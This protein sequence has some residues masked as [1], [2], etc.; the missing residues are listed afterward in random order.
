MSTLLSSTFKKKEMQA[1]TFLVSLVICGLA[2]SIITAPKIIELGIPFPF[3][4]IV[5]SILTYPIVDC[6]CELWGKEAARRA[7][8]LGLMTQ[9][10]MAG[11]IQ[12]SIIAPHPAFWTLQ[13][14]YELVLGKGGLVVFASL[15]AFSIS[16][17]LDI[18]IYQKLKELTQGRWLWLRSNVATY[19]GQALDSLARFQRLF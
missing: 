11:I 17:L 8:W 16:Q 3:S 12:L 15:I 13:K 5:F 2:A 4:N 19:F 6:I 9:V 7:M 14:E 1:Y 18:F 10:L